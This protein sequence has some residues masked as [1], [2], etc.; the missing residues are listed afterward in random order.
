ML[1]SARVALS[2]LSLIT[3]SAYAAGPAWLDGTWVGT[4]YEPPT[5]IAYSVQLIADSRTRTY[6]FE[7]ASLGCVG[8]WALISLSDSKA[9]FNQTITSGP[10]R[11]RAD[12]NDEGRNH[13]RQ[14]LRILARRPAGCVF[15]L[16]EVGVPLS[17]LTAIRIQ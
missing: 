14:L 16:D 5:R 10:M 12:R 8:S 1:M 17:R 3:A 9:T 4:G 7:A 15:D 2:L 11:K 6:I 13:L